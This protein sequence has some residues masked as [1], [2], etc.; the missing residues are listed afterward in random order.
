MRSN[1]VIAW[2]VA[3]ESL[4]AVTGCGSG[5][6]AQPVADAGDAASVSPQDSG[7]QDSG[8]QDSGENPDAPV[9]TAD[10]GSDCT[11]KTLKQLTSSSEVELVDAEPYPCNSP[12]SKDVLCGVYRARVHTTTDPIGST[13]IASQMKDLQVLLV[14]RAKNETAL[15]KNRWVVM[16]AGGFGGG[17][18]AQFGGVPPGHYVQ[19]G[20]YGDDFV[21]TLNDAGYV[22]VDVTYWCPTGTGGACANSAFKGW[23]DAS[24]TGV[25]KGIAWYKDVD[26]AGYLG[27][28]G[29]ARAIYDW[30][31]RNSGRTLCAH[32]QSSG[33]GRLAG[34]LTRY[35]GASM[36]DTVVFSGGPVFAYIPWMCSINEGPLGTRPDFYQGTDV[37]QL[38]RSTEDCANSTSSSTCDSFQACRQKKFDQKLVTDSHFYSA[39]TTSFPNIDFSVVMGGADTSDAWQHLRLWLPGITAQGKTLAGLRGRSLTLKQGYCSTA[40]AKY[41]PDPKNAS[42]TRPCSDWDPSAYSGNTGQTFSQA[43]EARIKDAPHEVPT[44]K[45]GA[46]VL[47]EVT[48]ATCEL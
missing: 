16:D 17:Y 13:G 26:G 6:A 2:I 35:G 25:N 29:R 30:A 37:G 44:T 14:V 11:T 22:T 38:V 45:E 5:N 41:T 46:D 3:T 31:F 42:V 39:T 1:A 20:T 7:S 9:S 12:D 23:A 19:G 36:F 24:T 15:C 27:I 10:A 43:Y 18:G 40:S 34:V 4:L 32:A 21:R 48:K 8:S 28:S 47:V 33:S